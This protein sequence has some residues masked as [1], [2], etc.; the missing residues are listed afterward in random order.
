MRFEVSK[1][2]RS[3]LP[4]LIGE[5]AAWECDRFRGWFLAFW[6]CCASCTTLAVVAGTIDSGATG[7][8]WA[9]TALTA[10][11]S[12]ILMRCELRANAV[13][14]TSARDYLKQRYGKDFRR[15]GGAGLLT[16]RAW[17]VYLRREFERLGVPRESWPAALRDE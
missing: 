11:G 1:A 5:D 17:H 13:A 15:P 12:A 7:W 4:E 16:L 3:E 6:C 14:A 2:R 8:L 10:V 9:G